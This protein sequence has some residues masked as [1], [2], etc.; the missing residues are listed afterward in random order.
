MLDDWCVTTFGKPYAGLS[1]SEV[2]RTIDQLIAWT[3]NDRELRLA[4]GQQELGL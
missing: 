4:M 2:S 1:R 3:E